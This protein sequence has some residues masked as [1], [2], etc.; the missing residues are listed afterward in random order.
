MVK[1]VYRVPIHFK[2][3]V[4]KIRNIDIITKRSRKINALDDF[5]KLR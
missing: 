3:H 1:P 2:G 5:R 4:D